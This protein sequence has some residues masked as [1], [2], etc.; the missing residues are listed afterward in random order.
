MTDERADFNIYGPT[1][2]G[3]EVR[4]TGLDELTITSRKAAQDFLDA[5][6]QATQRSIRPYRKGDEIRIVGFPK[7]YIAAHVATIEGAE[8]VFVKVSIG[9][10]ERYVGVDSSEVRLMRPVEARR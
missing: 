8:T 7:Q 5:S 9:G 1:G 6:R 4:E 3:I 2:D 10:K